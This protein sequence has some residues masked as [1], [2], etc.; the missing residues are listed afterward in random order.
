MRNRG[1]KQLLAYLGR[2]MDARLPWVF[3]VGNLPLP[4]LVRYSG[5]LRQMTLSTD[6]E[7]VSFTFFDYIN[8]FSYVETSLHPCDEAY[9]IIVDYFSDVFL[10]LICQYFVE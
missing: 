2:W 5:R 4:N 7:Q 9:L 6:N 3:S 1:R 8:G 10:D